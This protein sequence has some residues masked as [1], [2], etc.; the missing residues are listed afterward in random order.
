MVPSVFW[1]LNSEALAYSNY[2]MG[3]A[4]VQFIIKAR[5][6][7]PCKTVAIFVPIFSRSLASFPGYLIVF[8]FVLFRLNL[9]LLCQIWMDYKYQSCYF[10]TPSTVRHDQGKAMARFS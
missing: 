1:K 5:A 6:I 7:C 9:A 4:G 2:L 10:S 3:F 8:Y